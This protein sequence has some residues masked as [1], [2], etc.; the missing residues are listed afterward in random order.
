M[1]TSNL[2]HEIAIAP[3]A[4]PLTKEEFIQAGINPETIPIA[5]SAHLTS[6]LKFCTEENKP[7]NETQKAHLEIEPPEQIERQESNLVIERVERITKHSNPNKTEFSSSTP[8]AKHSLTDPNLRELD[9]VDPNKTNTY[10]SAWFLL[11]FIFSILA[12]VVSTALLY[13]DRDQKLYLIAPAVMLLL[14]CLY[15]IW[16][17][18]TRCCVCHQ[19]QFTMAKNR[20]KQRAHYIP[21]IGYVIPTALHMALRGFYRCMVCGSGI[22]LFKNKE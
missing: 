9:I 13:F 22:S 8:L 18:N 21:I 14:G 11:F 2:E 5:S 6:D 19:R 12:T 16:I 3:I 10:L 1:I 17:M 20:K 4:I 7:F 15:F